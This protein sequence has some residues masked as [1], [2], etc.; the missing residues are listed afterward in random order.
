[1]ANLTD[2]KSYKKNANRAD[3]L[4][5]RVIDGNKK[6]AIMLFNKYNKSDK[7]EI[8]NFLERNKGNNKHLKTYNNL[9]GKK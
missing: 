9:K 8:V 5:R 3:Y 4:E 1:M 7:K 2:K 6:E